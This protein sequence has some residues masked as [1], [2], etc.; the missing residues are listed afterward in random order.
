M[1]CPKPTE[2]SRDR[3]T[4]LPAPRLDTPHCK[5][6]QGPRGEAWS[7]L[8]WGG[9][10]V[11]TCNLFSDSGNLKNGLESKKAVGSPESAR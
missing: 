3:P 8:D 6:H 10:M 7:G 4:G 5:G 1:K 2:Q 11:G 9:G